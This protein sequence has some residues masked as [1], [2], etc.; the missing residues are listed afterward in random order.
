MIDFHSHILPGMDDGSKNVEESLQIL[1]LMADQGIDKVAATPHFY[2][3]LSGESPEEFLIRRNTAEQMLRERIKN[4]EGLPQIFC[5]AEVKYFRGMS[6][7]EDLKKLT[8]QGTELLLVG[9]AHVI[10]SSHCP[11]GFC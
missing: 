8:L 7:V 10:I 2:A 6:G 4:E 1:K 5:G 3:S 9:C 11:N